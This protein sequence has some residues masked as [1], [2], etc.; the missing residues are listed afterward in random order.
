[1]DSED[2]F[3][4]IG[5]HLYEFTKAFFFF[6]YKGLEKQKENISKTED[7]VIA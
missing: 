7:S 3:K 5:V 4:A 2:A 6:F 1:M